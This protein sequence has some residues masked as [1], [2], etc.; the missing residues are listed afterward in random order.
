MP[1][2]FFRLLIGLLVWCV[3]F[4]SVA[5]VAGVR[6]SHAA[7][8]AAMAHDMPAGMHHSAGMQMDHAAA[9]AHAHHHADAQAATSPDDA[10]TG[11]AMLGCECGCNCASMG[12]V[13][14]G[15]GIAGFSAGS[16]FDV[17]PARFSGQQPQ[18]GLRAAHG[19]DLIRPPSKS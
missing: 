17:P 2:P 16:A 14:N 11:L 18:A 12:C 10:K 15:L 19:L 1:L 9:D 13:V 3:G 6:C 5:A 7:G 4:Q 8:P